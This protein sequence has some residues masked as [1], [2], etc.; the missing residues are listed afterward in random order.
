MNIRAKE[1]DLNPAGEK[2]CEIYVGKAGGVCNAFCEAQDC[3]TKESD[4]SCDS[5]RDSWFELTGQKA[6]PCEICP[7]FRGDDLDRVTRDNMDLFKSDLKKKI[8]VG[9]PVKV[10]GD[11]K[12]IV[13]REMVRYEVN[14]VVKLCS[15][16][17]IV[18]DASV[19]LDQFDKAYD[20]IQFDSL[21]KIQ[22]DSLEKTRFK[23]FEA[24]R[25][26]KRITE[27][28]AF[29]SCDLIM[30]DKIAKLQRG[31]L[32]IGVVKDAPKS[33]LLPKKPEKP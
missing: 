14:S 22:F 3:N 1:A 16:A 4:P 15:A 11:E 8:L 10:G 7:C 31:D 18:P 23:E 20:E 25:F 6:F 28:T 26:E 21:E 19:G 9:M 30:E 17:K 32:K 27:V 29:R 24:T 12:E 13:S 2:V 33:V 5:L